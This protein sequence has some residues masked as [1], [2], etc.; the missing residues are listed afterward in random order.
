MLKKITVIF[1]T[2]MI[3]TEIKAEN[4]ALRAQVSAMRDQQ[5]KDLAK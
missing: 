4:K 1:F 5:Q 3:S 2:M